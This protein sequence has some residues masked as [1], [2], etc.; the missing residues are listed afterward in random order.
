MLC[1]STGNIV[2]SWTA[3]FGV[4]HHMAVM[5][6]GSYVVWFVNGRAVA[7]GAV[8]SSANFSASA[9][10]PFRIGGDSTTRV[11]RGLLSNVRLVTSAVYTALPSMNLPMDVVSGTLVHLSAPNSSASFADI[12]GRG[13]VVNA[14]GVVWSSNSPNQSSG[15]SLYF[16]G[17]TSSILTIPPTAVQLGTVSIKR[18][19]KTSTTRVLCTIACRAIS[20]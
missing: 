13:V 4:W 18:S 5:R 11:L 17:S 1:L 20:R 12:S 15:G 3:V 16:S 2:G 8:S 9:T 19:T 14:V 10:T 6:R 7:Y